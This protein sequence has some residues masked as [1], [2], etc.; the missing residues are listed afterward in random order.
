M[1]SVRPVRRCGTVI[2]RR[3]TSFG[4]DGA[5]ATAAATAAAIV[6][7]ASAAASAAVSTVGN[8]LVLSPSQDGHC[9]AN[10]GVNIGGIDVDGALAAAISANV[11]NVAH[12]SADASVLVDS[13]LG[14]GR[15]GGSCHNTGNNGGNILGIGLGAGLVADVANVVDLDAAVG[16]NGL[17]NLG[18]LGIGGGNHCNHGGSV[19]ATAA[20]TA[21]ATANGAAAAAAATVDTAEHCLRAIPVVDDIQV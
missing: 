11:A 7:D 3:P 19:V 16:A 9:H 18:G 13:L 21:A 4:Q 20:A 5:V 2:P 10:N 12:V 17:L 8:G 6:D 14:G 1:R 15:N